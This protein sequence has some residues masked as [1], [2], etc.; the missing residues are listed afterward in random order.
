[1]G[2]SPIALPLGHLYALQL[3]V[4]Y[5]NLAIPA[6]AARVAVNVRFFQSHGLPPGSALAVGALDGFAGFLVQVGL[7]IGLLTLTS[8]SLDLD[9]DVDVAGKGR[10]LLLI[11]AGVGL[12][13]LVVACIPRLRRRV[14][15]FVTTLVTEGLAAVRGLR[16][17]RRVG[18]LLGGNLATEIL[19]A[20]ALGAMT[21]AFGY[22]VGLDD[23]LLI[24]LTVSLLSGL[25]PVPGGI[26]V[27][28]AGLT[29]GL[30]SVG[31]PEET[32][33]AA[34]LLNRL[35]SF[36][37]PPIWGFFAFRWLERNHHL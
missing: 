25:I 11:L 22:P 32:A 2:A 18:L 4:S 5:V 35:A 24:N 36:Y 17:P 3:A 27:T 1:M 29:Y 8:A 14:V 6:S 20:S 7:L 31:M 9:L 21:R 28:E 12:V 26:G 37:L 23:L 19:F 34:V 33:L 30:V 15:D 13:A 10:I 16:S